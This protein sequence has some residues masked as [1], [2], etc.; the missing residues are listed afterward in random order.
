[1]LYI[2]CSLSTDYHNYFLAIDYYDINIPIYD[3]ILNNQ[4]QILIL[5]FILV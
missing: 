5:N 2:L 3:E 1:M 4:I